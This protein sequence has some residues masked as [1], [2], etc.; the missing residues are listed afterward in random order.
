MN[1]NRSRRKGFL[2]LFYRASNRILKNADPAGANAIVVGFVTVISMVTAVASHSSVSYFS[3]YVFGID[4]NDY[5]LRSIAVD[6]ALTTIVAASP[7]VAYC[8]GLI[9]HLRET[10]HKLKR[11]SPPPALP[12]MPNPSFSPI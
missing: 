12:T 4:T 8:M 10:K 2:A 9:R 5:P 1:G 3:F 11:A 7:M 6:A